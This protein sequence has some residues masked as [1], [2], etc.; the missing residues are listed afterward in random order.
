MPS[1]QRFRRKQAGTQTALLR[2]PENCANVS[3][4]LR[5][6]PRPPTTT[7]G[8]ST[9]SR[10]RPSG[11]PTRR[12]RWNEAPLRRPCANFAL[13][14]PVFAAHAQTSSYW[15]RF[16]PRCPG[17]AE[18]ALLRPAVLARR[19]RRC[20]TVHRETGSVSAKFFLGTTKLAPLAQGFRSSPQK[21]RPPNH[22]KPTRFASA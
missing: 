4:F 1:R 6:T 19:M 8:A 2:K 17:A 14:E 9:T 11:P 16:S 5:R 21:A 7:T 13:T 20:A 3:R 18:T 22:S 12:A 15:S 10:P